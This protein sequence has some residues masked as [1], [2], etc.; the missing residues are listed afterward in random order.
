MKGYLFPGQG[1]QFTGMGKDLYEGNKTIEELFEQSN[2]ILGFRISDIMFGSDEEALRRT[3]VTQPAIFIHSIA[4]ATLLGDTFIP[5]MAAGHSLGEYSALTA[6]G[7]LNFADGLRLV[8]ARANAMQK[9]C[10]MNPGTMAAIIGL[11]DDIVEEVCAA[12]D[13][14]VVPAN[15]NCPGQLVIS[16]SHSG[17]E[18]A[19]EAMMARGATKAVVL[20]VGGAFH[21]PLMEP[22][23]LELEKALMETVFATP[24]CPIYQNIDAQATSNTDTIRQKL[25]DQL[26]G[27]VRWTQTIQQMI[28]EGMTSAVETGGS[29][30]VLR[31]LL[32]RIDRNIPTEVA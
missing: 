30:A 18:A 21:S 6:C 29:G 22:A 10:E 3:D 17:I 16:G 27:A 13:D 19:C 23:R 2:E 4:K 5:G 8:A 20:Q 32:R 28:K 9:A 25:I 31:G 24:Q 15:Y 1:A 14:I 26:T 11:A 12:I 7:A